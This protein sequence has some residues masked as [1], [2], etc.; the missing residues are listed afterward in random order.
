VPEKRHVDFGASTDGPVLELAG[1]Q[2]LRQAPTPGHLMSAVGVVGHV[3]D[4]IIICET[5]IA[6][7]AK[8]IGLEDAAALRRQL[9]TA[10]AANDALHEQIAGTRASVTASLELVRKAALTEPTP[11]TPNGSLPMPGQTPRKRRPRA[12]A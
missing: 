9:E 3:I 11:N 7:A 4:E 5:C 1:G 10:E 8:L 2:S 12:A 6:E